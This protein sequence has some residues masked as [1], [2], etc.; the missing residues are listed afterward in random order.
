[1]S[2]VGF[3]GLGIMGVPMAEKLMAGGHELFVYDVKQVPQEI[4]TAGANACGNSKSVAEHAEV[5][6]VMV[7]DTPDVEK[8]LLAPAGWRK[9]L[10]LERRLLI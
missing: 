9:G 1:M 4:V 5:I 3:I 8:V 2:K 6:I 7:P 10:R